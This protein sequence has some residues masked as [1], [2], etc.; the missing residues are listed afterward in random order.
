MIISVV[1]MWIGRIMASY[2]TLLVTILKQALYVT[3]HCIVY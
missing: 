3:S 2:K 1:E